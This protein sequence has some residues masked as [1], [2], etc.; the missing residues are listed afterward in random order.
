[1]SGAPTTPAATSAALAPQTAAAPHAPSSDREHC[2]L[3][4]SAHTLAPRALVP[5]GVE[6][7]PTA[8]AIALA[9]ATQPKDTLAIEVDPA[10]LTI[11][12]SARGR[13]ADPARRVV[14]DATGEKLAA[15]SETDR[16]GDRILGRRMIPGAWPVDIG[17]ADAN[18]VWAP[19]GKDTYSKLWPLDGDGAVEALRGV[20]IE[21]KNE[22]G[23]AIA[24]RR[25][26][27]I[28]M[29]AATGNE[30]LLARGPLFRVMGLGPVLG[31]PTIAWGGA[32]ALVAWADRASPSD[33][34][35]LRM[36]KFTPGQAPP[37][38]TIF[39]PPAGGLGEQAMSPWLA[40]VG[41]GSF[42]FTWTEGPVSGHHVRGQTLSAEGAP[43]GD[44]FTISTEGVNAGQAQA[45]AL[46]DG[47]G[48]VAFLAQKGKAYEVVATSV[49]CPPK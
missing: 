49:R 30:E 23:F 8:N 1:M 18:I 21:L 19:H 3:E 39:Q 17:V 12:Q 31:S 25:S 33:G 10:T 41:H 4:G 45:A 5:T 35:S 9:F 14:T 40:A 27:A 44:A 47:R 38:A 26:G 32:A 16:H 37:D 13:S 29:G 43:V 24:F 2:A 48:V 11:A 15:L 34:W 36:T 6:V 20:P 22:K 46:P 42:L 28:W 7:V